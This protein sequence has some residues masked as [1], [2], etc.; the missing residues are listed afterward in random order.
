MEKPSLNGDIRGQKTM[1]NPW[2]QWLT[3]YLLRGADVILDA[4]RQNK[5]GEILVQTVVF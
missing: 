3:S 5:T 1:L 2:V 4:L